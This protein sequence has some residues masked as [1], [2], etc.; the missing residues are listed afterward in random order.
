MRFALMISSVA[1]GC[2]T[3]AHAQRT[4][5]NAVTA[6]QDAFGVSVGTERIGIY[7]DRDVR[8]FSPVT[9][10]NVRVDS[11]PFHLRAQRIKL[12]RTRL[13]IEVDGKGRLAFCP[14]LGTPLTVDFEKAI[15]APPG[16][17]ILKA[18]TLELYGIP[19]LYLP[20]F[21]MR[22]DEKLGLLP[23]EVAYRGRD[24]VF[25]QRDKH[26]LLHRQ[27]WRGGRRASLG[28]TLQRPVQ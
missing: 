19:V 22:S 14:C 28:A 10:G 4:T 2:A 7:N 8:G 13:G 18:P 5:E 1:L 20:W 16:D 25:R 26:R 15:V 27:V 23:P 6:A 12:T 11:P 24:G 17:L 3:G 21:W 9:A